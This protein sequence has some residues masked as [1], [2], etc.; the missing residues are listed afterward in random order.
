MPALLRLQ[1]GIGGPSRG[2]LDCLG[3]L[4]SATL[5]T[6]FPGVIGTGLEKQVHTAV[7][8][9][10]VHAPWH[11]GVHVEHLPFVSVLEAI[12]VRV[13]PLGEESSWNVDGEL[14]THNALSARVF[15]GAVEV[16]ARGVE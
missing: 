11:A 8:L 16:F 9:S 2:S 4:K 14:M 15:R 10:H 6:L 1:C 7:G 12:A 5:S 3:L 13:Q